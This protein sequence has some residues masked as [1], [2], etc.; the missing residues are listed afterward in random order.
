VNYILI[1][2]IAVV[3]IVLVES[4]FILVLRSKGM[5][6]FSLS[7][8]SGVPLISLISLIFSASIYFTILI[9][10]MFGFWFSAATH[11][12]LHPKKLRN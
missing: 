1:I 6:A 7:L 2:K 8:L 12:F 3:I 9:T 5:D 11:G 4:V 10:L